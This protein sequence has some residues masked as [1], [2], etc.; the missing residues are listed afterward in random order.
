M[1]SDL[2]Y[3]STGRNSPPTVVR[4]EGRRDGLAV[5]LAGCRLGRVVTDAQED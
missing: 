3:P 5:G 2:D 4:D 1:G